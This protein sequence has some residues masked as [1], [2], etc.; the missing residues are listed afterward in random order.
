ML[1]LT[2]TLTLT[3]D[4]AGRG[5]SGP[6]EHRADSGYCVFNLTDYEHFTKPN[7]MNEAQQITHERSAALM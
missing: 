5:H 3:L 2:L 7:K 6:R 4:T 1:T